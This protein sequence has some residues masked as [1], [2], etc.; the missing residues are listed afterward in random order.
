MCRG[1]RRLGC[2]KVICHGLNTF[3]QFVNPPQGKRR[4]LQNTAI[5]NMWVTL[6]EAFDLL[7]G[8]AC[9]VDQKYRVGVFTGILKL[10]RDQIDVE[11]L[12]RVDQSSRF[13]VVVER[14]L[15]LR[16]LLHEVEYRFSVECVFKKVTSPNCLRTDVCRGL[17]CSLPIDLSIGNSAWI[18]L[19]QGRVPVENDIMPKSRSK[20]QDCQF[21]QPADSQLP[22][23]RKKERGLS[24]SRTDV[25]RSV[26]DL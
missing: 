12:R 15:M 20:L 13:H 23:T 11:P 16:V 25:F 1:T 9:N 2:E 26:L 17:A 19:R 6:L 24:Y 14:L 22:L 3:V 21:I 5:G 7:A 10:C 8:P 18:P 4:V